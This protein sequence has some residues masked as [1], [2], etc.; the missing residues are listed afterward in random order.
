MVQVDSPVGLWVLEVALVG[1]QSEAVKVDLEGCRI[2]LADHTTTPAGPKGCPVRV[3]LAGHIDH[4]AGSKVGP[5]R[6]V[7]VG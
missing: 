1:P 5:G 3:V 7:L 4:Q 6:V 2:A